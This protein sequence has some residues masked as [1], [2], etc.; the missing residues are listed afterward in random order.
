M[1]RMR[2]CFIMGLLI[3]SCLFNINLHYTKLGMPSVDAATEC[4]A[5]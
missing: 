3:Y 1:E 2:S 5:H 4:L